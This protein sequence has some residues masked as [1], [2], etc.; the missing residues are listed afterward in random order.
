MRTGCQDWVRTIRVV[1]LA[2]AAVLTGC[3]GPK[4]PA[5]QP[6]VSDP[7]KAALYVF[8]ETKGGL[9]QSAVE[10]SINQQAA[11]A[12]HPGQYLVRIVPP[13]EYFVRAASKSSMVRVVKLVAGDVVYFRVTTEPFDGKRPLLDILDSDTARRIIAA[14]TRVGE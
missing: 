1:F 9:D 6:E 11:G 13:G 2:V 12:L 10:I 7:S 4:G 8:R 5:F 14:T 3:S